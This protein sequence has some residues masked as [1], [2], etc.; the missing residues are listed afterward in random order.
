MNMKKISTSALAKLLKV[1][2]KEL[3]SLLID[4]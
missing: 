4:N 1:D 3:I 2:S